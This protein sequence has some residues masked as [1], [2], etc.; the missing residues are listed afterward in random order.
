MKN[1]FDGILVVE[2]KTDV[3]LLS[4]YIDAEYVTTN[5]SA[6]SDDVINYLKFRS[7]D[8]KIVVLTDP[9]SPG[10]RIRDII[11]QNVNNV[12][13]CFIEK[14]HAVKHHK[15]GV[16]EC[17]IDY[18]LECLNNVVT[19]SK[20]TNPTLTMSDLYEL[21]IIGQ[22]SEE[23]KDKISNHYHLGYVN[24]KT[25]LKR[26]NGLNVTKEELIKLL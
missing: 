8:T 11:E 15:V 23:I 5:G 1:H 4:T 19:F 2:G 12:Y 10:K 7:T 17:D 18:L 3:A 22:G 25:L 6:I 20:P 9:D 26:L 24:A 21:N 14:K 13:H 16:A